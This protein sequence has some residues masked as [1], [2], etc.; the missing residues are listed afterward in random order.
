[1]SKT[2]SHDPFGHLKHKL[3]PKERSGVK[4][5]VWFRPLKVKN[6]PDFLM[7]KWR[8]TY[9]WKALKK[10]YNFALDL[11]SIGGLHIKLWGPK[12]MGIPILGFWDSQISRQNTIWM[13]ASWRGTKYT[14][15]GKVVASPKS[16]PW[17]VLWVRV[18]PWFVLAPKVLQLCINQ[19]IMVLCRFVWVIKC[20]S[21]FL[22]PSQNSS[23]PLYPPPPKCYEPKNVFPTFYFSIVFTSD[24]HLNLSRSL[25]AHQR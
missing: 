3:W 21:F 1:M 19:F 9:H 6:R 25:G 11:I 20:L 15:K 12:V 18:W 22:V 17:W 14:I 16:R 4:L 10:G 7:C 5:A 13:W 8:A 24:S 23:T 2:R